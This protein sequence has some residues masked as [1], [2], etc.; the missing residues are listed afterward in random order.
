MKLKANDGREKNA[1][2]L[3]NRTIILMETREAR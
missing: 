3:N 1:Y 2:K